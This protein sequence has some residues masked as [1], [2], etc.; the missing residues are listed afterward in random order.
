MAGSVTQLQSYLEANTDKKGTPLYD[1][2]LEKLREL[3]AV[4][5][6][7]AMQR[8]L[9]TRARGDVGF[10]AFA[11]GTPAG[12]VIEGA[13]DLPL[14]A[15][16]FITESLGIEGMNEF[17]Q[18]REQRIQKGREATGSE[19]FDA[20]RLLGNIGTGAAAASG[21]PLA[22]GVI[23]KGLQGSGLGMVFGASTPAT[24]D[25]VGAEKAGQI[26]T[27]GVAGGLLP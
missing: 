13:A 7:P 4:D 16:Q 15:V 12:R 19:G 17:M 26:L 11:A 25:D 24:S 9:E 27:G 1:S 20:A 5:V 3:V 10:A 22:A 23:G 6:P 21:I 8:A 18:K 14:G 2:A